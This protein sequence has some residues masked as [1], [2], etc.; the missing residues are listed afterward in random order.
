[1]LQGLAFNGTGIFLA[2]CGPTGTHPM[3]ALERDLPS[4]CLEETFGSQVK[5]LCFHPT[6]LHQ[7]LWRIIGRSWSSICL[8]PENSLQERS[9]TLRRGPSSGMMQQGLLA[10]HFAWETGCLLGSHMRR[11]EKIRSCPIP[12]TDPTELCWLMSLIHMYDSAESVSSTGPAYPSTSEYM[13]MY[14]D[15]LPNSP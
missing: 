5:Q 7:Q 10:K 2:S 12:G 11:Q 6:Q 14:S 15:S 4:S 8:Q 9:G 13:Y 1:M 3:K